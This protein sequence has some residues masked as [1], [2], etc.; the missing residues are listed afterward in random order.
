VNVLHVEDECSGCLQ[1]ASFRFVVLS[2]C[3]EPASYQE[4][5]TIK[6]HPEVCV[7]W[8][9]WTNVPRQATVVARTGNIAA[10]LNLMHA[11][12]HKTAQEASEK[13][14]I[15][16]SYLMA[17]EFGSGN[18]QQARRLTFPD[19]FFRGLRRDTLNVSKRLRIGG[20]EALYLRHKL[21]R[22]LFNKLLE[23]HAAALK[24][25]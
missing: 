4:P 2:F 5:P 9:K 8:T 19:E 12:G 1:C 23:V 21:G 20:Y 14:A 10:N 25:Q 3:E 22:E 13:K 18:F 16:R 17:L 11:S 6:P 24:V 15:L 7:T